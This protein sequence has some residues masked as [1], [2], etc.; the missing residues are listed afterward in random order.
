MASF[1]LDKVR[2]MP[3][4]QIG[5]HV[6][7]DWEL[8]YIIRGHGRRTL[9]GNSAPFTVGDVVLV[10]P[11]T[12]HEWHFE[13][14]RMIENI[15][16]T[17][18]TDFLI[19]VGREFSEMS[20]VTDAIVKHQM[21]VCFTHQTLHNLHKLLSGMVDMDDA[22]RLVSMLSILREMALSDDIRAADRQ[23]VI[24]KQ[25]WLHDVEIYVC[26]NYRRRLT[27]DLIA[28]HMSMSRTSFCTRFRRESGSTF[29]NYLNDFRLSI[30]RQLLA[31]GGMK[32]SE[33]C[34]RSGFNDVPYFTRLFRLRFGVSPGQF[35][36]G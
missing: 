15:T 11:E 8:S 12:P 30:A 24:K 4:E 25:G 28:S 19:L 9:A 23:V 2:L 16:L 26:C 1:H 27:V 14:D 21:P 32:V 18:T 3:Q 33:V 5:L 13:G 36:A 31:K 10:P 7:P 17:F 35:R 29:V 20:S 22:G 6:Q 34:Y